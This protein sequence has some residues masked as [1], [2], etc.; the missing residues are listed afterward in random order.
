MRRIAIWGAMSAT[1]ALALAAAALAQDH[2]APPSWAYAGAGTPKGPLSETADKTIPGSAQTV[3][4]ARLQMGSEI[5]DWFPDRH[6]AMPPVV[7]SV[8]PP[9]LACAFCHLPNGAGRPENAPIAGLPRAYFI[10]QLAAMRSGER[11]FPGIALGPSRAMHQAAM[12]SSPAEIEQAADYFA[13]IP[14]AAP[15][16]VVESTDIPT[17]TAEGFIWHFATD[18]AHEPLGERIV[19]GPEKFVDFELRNL[20]TRFVAYVPPGSVAR[21]AALAAGA[22]CAACHGDGLKGGEIGP[23]LAGRYPTGAFR[24]LWAFK[25]GVRGGAG[26]ALMKPVVAGLSDKDM[27]DLA[28]YAGTLKP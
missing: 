20:D 8:P 19:E 4:A 14:Y 23:P 22:G 16:R 11:G 12:D 13:K 10:E 9:R 15:V 6:P 5:V 25:N 7:K 1:A 2:P 27:I 3:S 21:G 17:P 18:G 24:Q 28:A 26:A